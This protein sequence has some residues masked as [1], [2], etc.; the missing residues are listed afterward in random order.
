MSNYNSIKNLSQPT[1]GGRHV[2]TGTLPQLLARSCTQRDPRRRKRTEESYLNYTGTSSQRTEAK[3]EEK[4]VTC[5]APKNGLDLVYRHQT[6]MGY[7]VNYNTRSVL[8][9]ESDAVQLA[10]L[11]HDSVEGVSTEE[12][13]KIITT[14]KTPRQSEQKFRLKELHNDVNV[15]DLSPT[16]YSIAMSI[17]SYDAV[18]IT[19]NFLQT[20]GIVA[21]YQ[22]TDNTLSVIFYLFKSVSADGYYPAA[23]KVTNGLIKA[24]GTIYPDYRIS[25]KES[26]Y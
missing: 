5:L 6:D 24:L 3:T 11:E 17:G 14:L 19:L 8:L 25:F 20:M 13:Q 9:K 4:T 16:Q 23:A 7:M 18:D 12:A 22:V 2:A 21:D 1:F 15:G 10:W 26:A